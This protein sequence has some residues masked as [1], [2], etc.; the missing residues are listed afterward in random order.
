[1]TGADRPGAPALPS[2]FRVGRFG[3]GEALSI[4]ARAEPSSV[5]ALAEDLLSVLEPV[6]V[7]RSRTGLVM[8][9]CRDTAKGALFHLGEVLVAEALVRVPGRCECEGYGACL[10]RD[11]EHALAIAVVDAAAQAE[12]DTPKLTAF[13]EEHATR[14]AEADDAL[15]RRVEATRVSM[16]TF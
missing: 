4:L 15:L 1:M 6:E 7:V 5:K 9:P 13:L 12:I 14:L 11:L 10:G 2:G 3:H 8:V 16:E